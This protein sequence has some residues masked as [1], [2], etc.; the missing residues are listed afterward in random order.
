MA[1]TSKCFVLI[2]ALVVGALKVALGASD[3]VIHFGV[4]PT[5]GLAS[6]V[7]VKDCP[8]VFTSQLLPSDVH[9]ELIGEGDAAAQTDQVLQ[10]LDR[11]LQSAKSDLAHVV[12]LNVYVAL[13]E[14]VPAVRLSLK[15][16]FAAI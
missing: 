1:S 8:L 13:P 10:S 4:D 12:K 16:R 15:R 9:G 5:S 3:G 14:A 7:V 6:A 2:C 11:V